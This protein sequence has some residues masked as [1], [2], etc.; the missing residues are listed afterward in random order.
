VAKKAR[1]KEPVLDVLFGT[2][3]CHW[4]IKSAL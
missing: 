4:E 2:C 3:G 1:D